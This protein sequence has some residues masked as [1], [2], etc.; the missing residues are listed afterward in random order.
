MLRR[1]CRP[2]W[3]RRRSCSS[4]IRPLDSI[5]RSIRRA[6]RVVDFWGYRLSSLGWSPGRSG[7][8]FFFSRLACPFPARPQVL[9]EG[10]APSAPVTAVMSSVEALA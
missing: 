3:W 8:R 4:G 9:F 10:H 1:D 5:T 6:S 2:G 7:L